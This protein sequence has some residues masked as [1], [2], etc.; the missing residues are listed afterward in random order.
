MIYISNGLL[1]LYEIVVHS[2]IHIHTLL[3]SNKYTLIHSLHIHCLLFGC[4]SR[5][6]CCVMLLV[7]FYWVNDQIHPI[8]V[9]SAS[10]LLFLLS[11][12]FHQGQ[13]C[14]FFAWVKKMKPLWESRIWRFLQQP[15]FFSSS[16]LTLM[17][18]FSTSPLLP[19]LENGAF[20]GQLPRQ[21][22][23][24]AAGQPVGTT[25]GSDTSHL[26]QVWVW[27]CTCPAPE[28][29]HK[30]PRVTTGQIADGAGD[31]GALRTWS[32]FR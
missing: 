14:S 6:I 11:Y 17:S 10:K 25:P 7:Y 24:S 29:Q 2:F 22:E 27:P 19:V 23:G 1:L 4:C 16:M 31:Q 12:F 32:E 26:L 30:S 5:H 8:F 28:G 20:D 18:I 13:S 15:P 3:S 21:P 9:R